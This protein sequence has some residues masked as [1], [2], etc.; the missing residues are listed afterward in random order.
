MFDFFNVLKLN[1]FPVRK[2]L[3]EYERNENIPNLYNWQIK[4]REEL[5]NYHFN[6]NSFYRNILKEMPDSWE[7]IPIMKKEFFQGDYENMIPSVLS[8]KDRYVSHTSGSSGTPMSFVKDKFSHALTWIYISETY[9]NVGVNINDLQ[10]RFFAIPLKKRRYLKERFKDYMMNRRR[11]IVFDLED[12]VFEKWVSLFSKKKFKYINGYSNTILTF[13][14]YLLK[15]NIVLKDKC[16]SLKCCIVTSEMCSHRDE[17]IIKKALGIPVFNEYG[18]SELGIIGF[19]VDDLWEVEDR[20][21]YVEVVD[22]EG[23]VLKDGEKGRLLC[24]SLYN[25]ATPFIRY[26]IGDIAS[27]SRKNGKTYISDLVGRINEMAILPSGKKF[28]G[29]TFNYIINEAQAN[30][31]IITEYQV[32]QVSEDEFD[33]YVVSDQRILDELKEKIQDSFDRYL[34]PG[35]N[36]NVVQVEQIKRSASG[37]FKDFYRI[38]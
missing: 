6:N 35:L 11:F 27:I 38:I 29:S 37:K 17:Q 4:K 10:A 32:V 12:K 25:K 8:K 20:L 28:P 24:T 18:A 19:K 36:T 9:N 3:E 31:D 34:E 26:E 33:I 5:L 15:N 21:F 2:A 14:R 7:K 23:N 16:P 1:G 22:E 13:S 30:E